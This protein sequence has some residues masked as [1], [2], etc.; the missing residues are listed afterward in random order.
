M[1]SGISHDDRTDKVEMLSLNSHHSTH[2]PLKMLFLNEKNDGNSDHD[3][4]CF[5]IR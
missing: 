5:S 2:N 1:L 4:T 3:A